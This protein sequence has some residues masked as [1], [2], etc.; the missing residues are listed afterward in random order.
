MNALR[1]GCA[2]LLVAILAC[3][4]ETPTDPSAVALVEHGFNAAVTF[5]ERNLPFTHQTAVCGETQ[6]WEGTDH[7]IEQRTETASG[8]IL[9]AFR[10]NYTG[11]VTGVP[12]GN[13]YKLNGHFEFRQTFDADGYPYT[14]TNTETDVLIGKGSAPNIVLH[15]VYK[16]TI[17]AN[18]DV[19]IQRLVIDERCQ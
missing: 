6:L 19:S 7:W 10:S 3:S 11:T 17:N 5:H 15:V 12:S 18:G 4:D 9:S 13:V 8:R 2:C 16:V 1:I 14:V